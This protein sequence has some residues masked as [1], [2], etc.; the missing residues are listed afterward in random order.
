M[1]VF[2]E[3]GKSYVCSIAQGK[4]TNDKN[5]I[6]DVAV[7]AMSDELT[8][9]AIMSV[10]EYNALPYYWFTQGEEAKKPPATWP[11]RA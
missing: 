6:Q 4:I 10:D 8:V 5:D 11:V 2:T 3:G 7:F 9:V 1:K